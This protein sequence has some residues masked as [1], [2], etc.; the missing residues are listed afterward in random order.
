[1]NCLDCASNDRVTPAVGICHDCG[2]GVCVDHAVTR[3]HYLKR[4]LTIALEVAVE[5]PARILRCTVCSA[6]V[7]AASAANRPQHQRRSA[8]VSH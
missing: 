4:I 7:D 3:A 6:A 5:P 8:K 2:A 1:M